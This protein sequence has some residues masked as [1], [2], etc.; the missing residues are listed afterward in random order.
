MSAQ[1][2]A[3]GKA[4]GRLLS[5]VA[6]RQRLAGLARRAHLVCLGLAGLYALL[7]LVS[8][9]LG[10][11]PDWFD[12]RTVA[13]V[14]A[15]ALAVSVLWHQRPTVAEAARLA[16]TR[17]GTNDLFLTASLLA[18]APGD[19]KPIVLAQAEERAAKVAPSSIVP[20]RWRAKS[21]HVAGAL[22]SL[23]LGILFLPQLDPFGREEQRR[24]DAQRR[25]LLAESRK[26]TELRVAA[27]EKHDPEAKTSE[28]VRNAIEDLK[29]TFKAMKPQDRD[30]NLRRLTEAQ[31]DLSELWKKR[32][33]ERLQDA[34][35][36]GAD[37]QRLGAAQGQK[38]EQWKRRLQRGDPSEVKKEVQDIAEKAKR[39]AQATNAGERRRL[40]DEIGQ[41]LRGLVDFVAN[42][43]RSRPVQDAINRALEQLAAC[44]N[45]GLSKD[46]MKAL[47][48]SLQLTQME[49]DAF[50]Q[51]IRDLQALEKG[52]S[53]AQLAKILN[54]AKGLDGSR[55][56][57][58]N[59]IED[60][61]RHYK[62]LV[63]ASGLLPTPG[64]Q[65]EGAHNDTPGGTGGPR[66]GTAPGGRSQEPREEQSAFQTERS[67]SAYT[68][69]KVLLQ[70]KVREMSDPGSVRQ[71]HQ[72]QIEAVQGGV[73]EAILQEQVPPG[74]HGAIQRYFDSL[75]E[76]REE[77]PPPKWR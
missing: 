30:G 12:P 54:T 53:A 33:E 17:A 52:L 43:A 42:N 10:L 9:L 64:T 4:T 14:P 31:K 28:A 34:F 58:F 51:A 38:A 66:A 65:G 40:Q 2:I 50:A 41:Q 27:L 20:F 7:L 3:L 59:D 13:V 45:K 32:S 8:R 46:A 29:Q 19:F 39:L 16:D 69:G 15:V 37:A 49:M 73:R 22:A 26:A 6:M 11:I 35:E 21:A 24:Q 18:G 68:A 77:P 61:E 48:E 25:R 75:N 5:Q 67:R 36:K 57:G 44:E 23:L 71:N 62:E 76:T 72:A 63:A 47:R 60:Y 74:Y 56:D 1:G 70:W 55:T